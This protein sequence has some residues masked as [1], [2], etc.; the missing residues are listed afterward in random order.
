[1]KADWVT[2]LIDARSLEE[3]W[4][5]AKPSIASLLEKEQKH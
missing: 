1:M 2:S 3:Q 5:Q 4:R